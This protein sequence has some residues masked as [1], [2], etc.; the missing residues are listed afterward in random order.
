VFR[1]GLDADGN[2]V[3]AIVNRCCAVRF[4][5]TEERMRYDVLHIAGREIVGL[6]PE[7]FDLLAFGTGA[8]VR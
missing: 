4:G 3:D 1:H 6:R 8:M 7:E 5:E 2:V